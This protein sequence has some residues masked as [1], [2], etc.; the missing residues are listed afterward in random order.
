MSGGGQADSD[1]TGT[2]RFR[3]SERL[4]YGLCDGSLFYSGEADR[5][6]SPVGN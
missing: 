2:E 4:F 1:G 6:T 3:V 5:R